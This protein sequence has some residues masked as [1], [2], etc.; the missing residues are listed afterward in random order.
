MASLGA[1]FLSFFFEGESGLMSLGL[2]LGVLPL[3]LELLPLV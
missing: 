3:E 2:C 1:P